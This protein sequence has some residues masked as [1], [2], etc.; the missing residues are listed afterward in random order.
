MISFGC[1][2]HTEWSHDN[3]MIYIISIRFKCVRRQQFAIYVYYDK[4]KEQEW[5]SA[6]AGGV[7]IAVHHHP[8][9]ARIRMHMHLCIWYINQY[10][11]SRIIPNK[12]FR[13]WSSSRGGGRGSSHH[14]AAA[15]AGAKCVF[16][17]VWPTV[18]IMRTHKKD[19]YQIKKSRR[20]RSGPSES[21]QRVWSGGSSVYRSAAAVAATIAVFVC[22]RC[23]WCDGLNATTF[24]T[25]ADT[26]YTHHR[27]SRQPATIVVYSD[28]H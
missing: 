24:S 27:R 18:C 23:S 6:A 7:I 8:I 4:A 22:C 20:R 5:G 1:D 19:R 16:V 28:D 26:A 12:Y 21:V 25:T 17:R 2:R 14:A 10:T 9:Y 11:G 15:A 3:T 13:T